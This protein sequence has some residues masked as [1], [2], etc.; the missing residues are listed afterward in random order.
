[1]DIRPATLVREVAASEA[2]SEVVNEAKAFTWMRRCEVALLRVDSG[3]L[4]L[5]RGGADGIEFEVT[6]DE[7]FVKI[8]GVRRRVVL[9]AWHTHPRP[10]GP[11]DQDRRF[12][13]K[14]N[15]R[16]SVIYEMF[17]DGRGTRFYAADR[18]EER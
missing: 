1:M 3:Q 16:S 18:V 10:T 8:D 11:S 17:G 4:L 7:V 12:L 13:A 5:V 6:Y 2:W 15:Q 9:L 14:L